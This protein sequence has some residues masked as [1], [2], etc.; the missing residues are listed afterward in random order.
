MSKKRIVI[1]EDER[2]MADLVATRLLRE[3]YKVDVAYDGSQGFELIRSQPPDLVVLDLMLPGM[4]GTQIAARLRDD[5]RTAGIAILMLTARSEESDI[6]VGL[7]FGADDYVTKPFSMS[8]LVARID[9]LLR[10]A[11]SAPAMTKGVFKAGPLVIDQHRYAVDHDGR[12]I[13]LTL[14]EF[15]L[16]AALAVAKG[17]VLTRSQLMDQAI[18]LDTVV[19][20]RTIDVHVTT[21]RRKLGPAR[22]CIQTVRGVGYKFADDLPEDAAQ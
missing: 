19:T 17:R 9:A 8:V 11:A 13:S 21:L 10:R 4:P 18:G 3:G 22:N 14:T 16:L 5:P 7:K 2:D 15:K 12:N 20:D 6:V 1:V